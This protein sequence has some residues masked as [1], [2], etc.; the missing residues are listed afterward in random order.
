ML[1]LYHSLA[2]PNSCRVWIALL[3]KELAF[4]LVSLN[5]NG[6]QMLS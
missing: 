6:E 2:S 3:E 1:K 5:L 4:E